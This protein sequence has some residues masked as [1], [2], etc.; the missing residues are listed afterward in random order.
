MT[1]VG[2][3]AVGQHQKRRR[4]RV[5]AE[6]PGRDLPARPRFY[7]ELAWVGGHGFGPSIESGLFQKAY[8]R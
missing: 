4:S 5:C 3:G 7:S 6:V 1:L 8:F 2:S